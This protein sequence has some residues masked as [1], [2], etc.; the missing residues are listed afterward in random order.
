MDNQKQD[1]NFLEPNNNN[2]L[3]EEIDEQKKQ[4]HQAKIEQ[5]PNKDFITELPDWDLLPPNDGVKR[6]VR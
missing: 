2:T 6:V 3:F 4:E 5:N 1:L